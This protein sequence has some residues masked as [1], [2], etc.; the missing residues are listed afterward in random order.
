MC[1]WRFWSCWRLSHLIICVMGGALGAVA[2]YVGLPASAYESL[3]WSPT[4]GSTLS[5]GA[6]STAFLLPIAALTTDVLLRSLIARHPIE[7]SESAH[8][9][10]IYD[11]IMLRAVTFL[12]GV[13]AVV[14]AGSLGM[15]AGH[16]WAAR[17]VPMML[18]LA[19][20][21]VG[22]LLPRTRPNLAIGIR[23]SYTLSDRTV[24]MQT[25]RLVGRLIALGGLTVVL[26]AAVL[27]APIGTA[28]VLA[29]GPV[30]LV[31]SALAAVHASRRAS[32]TTAY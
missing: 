7:T 30:V 21:G 2:L 13:H 14:L 31:G 8:L 23:T 28:S 25:H 11:A 5:L 22:N 6:M 3:S 16:A 12:M 4:G 26:A 17:L 9:P 24:W 10:S 1:S 19:M 32:A 20:M 15:L 29:V 18:G 27:P